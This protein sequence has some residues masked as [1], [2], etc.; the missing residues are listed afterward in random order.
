MKNWPI[1]LIT[2]SL[3]V[4]GGSTLFVG[5]LLDKNQAFLSGSK[6]EQ[7]VQPLREEDSTLLTLQNDPKELFPSVTPTLAIQQIESTIKFSNHTLNLRGTNDTL[8]F[9]MQFTANET[10]YYWADAEVYTN[11]SANRQPIGY[12]ISWGDTV[13]N[14]NTVTAIFDFCGYRIREADFDGPYAIYLVFYYG[15]YHYIF[16]NGG[17]E[18][19]GW[20][21]SFKATDFAAVPVNVDSVSTSF[22]D[23]DGNGLYEW[24]DVNLQLTVTITDRYYI[25]GYFRFNNYSSG[26]DLH[27]YTYI[28]L[29]VGSPEVTLRYPTWEFNDMGIYNTNMTMDYLYFRHDTS[30]SWELFSYDPAYFTTAKY[31]SGDFDSFP[32][33]LTGRVWED[34]YDSDGDLDYDSYRVIVEINKTRT[35]IDITSSGMW[36]EL[37]VNSSNDY[38]QSNYAS[39]D[40]V[41]IGTLGFTNVT[42]EFSKNDYDIYRKGMINDHFLL[43]NI[44]GEVYSASTD[45]YYQFY[46]DFA[47]ISSQSY[48]STDF[49]GPVA[50][51]TGNFLNYGE[52]TDG[53]TLFNL[54]VVEAEVTIIKDDEFRIGANLQYSGSTSGE[55]Y[56][57]AGTHWITLNFEAYEIH[58]SG[59]INATIWLNNIW[60]YDVPTNTEQ[61]Y[62]YSFE[63]SRYNYTQFDPPNAQFYPVEPFSDW[64]QDLDTDGLYDLLWISVDVTINQPGYYYV[65]GYLRNP[66]TGYSSKQG[67]SGTSNVISSGTV[68]F[69]LSFPASWIWAQH[70]TNTSLFVESIY[71]TEVDEYDNHIRQWDSLYDAYHT[72]PYDSNNFEAPLAF[73]T[74]NI[75]ER[76]LDTDADGKINILT[77]S[78]EVDVT[79]DGP[80]DLA[81]EGWLDYGSGEIYWSNYTSGLGKGLHWIDMYFITCNLY[82]TF[83]D[84]SY[85]FTLDLYDDSDYKHLDHFEN[86]TAFYSYQL[87]DSFSAYFTGNFYDQGID[88]DADGKYNHVALQIEVNITDDSEFYFSGY[89]ETS[90]GESSWSYSSPWMNLSTGVQNLTVNIDKEWF[91]YQADGLSVYNSYIY[92]EERISSFGS[93]TADYDGLNHYFTNI[94]YASDFDLPN[95]ILTGNYYDQGVDDDSDGTFDYVEL[96]IELNITHS[97]VY[98]IEGNIYAD[99]GGDGWYY[100]TERRN[101]SPGLVNVTIQ[102]SKEWFYWHTPGTNIYNAY[103]YLYQFDGTKDVQIG[104]D[105]EDH[106]FSRKYYHSDFDLRDAW[107]VGITDDFAT[108]I[109]SDGFYDLWTVVFEVEVTLEGIG[110]ELE[111]DLTEKGTNDWIDYRW[112]RYENL[113]IGRHN[114]TVIFPSDVLFSS[115]FTQGAQISNFRLIN[116]SNW[117]DLDKS[118]DPIP[119]SGANTFSEFDSNP[120][121]FIKIGLIS[122][123]IGVFLLDDS[124]TFQVLINKFGSEYVTSVDIDIAVN[125][126]HYKTVPLTKTADF[127]T[128]DIWAVGLIFDRSGIWNIVVNA[129]SSG[130]STETGSITYHVLGGPT[131]FGF[132]VNSSSVMVGGAIQFEADVWDVDGIQSL[133]LHVAGNT[134]PMVHVGNATWGERWIVVV[135]FNTAG[136]YSAYIEGKD[137]VGDTSQSSTLAIYVNAGPEIISVDVFPNNTVDVGTIVNF[138]VVISK[139]EAIIS[140]VTLEVEDEEGLHY[141]EVFVE[142]ASTSSTITYETSFRPTKSGV[143]TCTIR[144]VTTQNQQSSHIE[145]LT[146]TGEPE[147]VKISPGFEFVIVLG[148]LILLPVSRKHL[149]KQK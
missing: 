40:Q 11:N 51:V 106:Y 119:L 93:I 21:Q 58:R 25:S 99:D 45:R 96:S 57:T 117:M 89:I 46:F 118:Y 43:N 23:N 136:Q 137:S 114:I 34:P 120:P 115:G 5:I 10:A 146:V 100:Y 12:S 76:L 126:L 72:N 42:F 49:D 24:I 143:H 107:V 103:T 77:I 36:A 61:D 113:V 53:D 70:L 144:V 73:F 6:S 54:L 101:F 110:L 9:S 94:Y 50:W 62:Q 139:S 88:T 129:H 35:D 145:I 3:L 18:F 67:N 82:E 17:S 90:G 55:F 63:L 84:Q 52:D 135:T 27:S 31:N 8:R 109:D 65:Y 80:S 112:T 68:S 128:H 48:D 124:T 44:R 64:G 141:T 87:F 74:G 56:L 47:W 1:F 127:D 16:G 81:L 33:G 134:Y 108:D 149:R 95:A 75:Q 121:N 83:T 147:D 39:N 138:T 7:L 123:M 132:T 86:Q 140:S 111:V 78:A 116:I 32:F 4:I 125:G 15:D 91:W 130:G 60:I 20:T 148:L 69:T 38:I 66:I 22:I 2:L 28:N 97:G 37:R 105:Q 102:I 142:T 122:P 133:T 79:I 19:I 71:I 14:G 131:F 85:S 92:L 13:A 29:N 98:T 104:Y 41:Q 26:Y 59:I 30:P